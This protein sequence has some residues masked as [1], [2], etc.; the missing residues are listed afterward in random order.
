MPTTISLNNSRMLIPIELWVL[1]FDRTI[2]ET[3][4]YIRFIGTEKFSMTLSKLMSFRCGASKVPI[5][6]SAQI[7]PNCSLKTLVF[8][9]K[10]SDLSIVSSEHGNF[11]AVTTN[12]PFWVRNGYELPTEIQVFDHAKPSGVIAFQFKSFNEESVAFLS[13]KIEVQQMLIYQSVPQEKKRPIYFYQ[14]GYSSALEFSLLWRL[15]HPIHYTFL[16]SLA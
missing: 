6:T 10:F 16:L 13:R 2:C 7:T 5:V 1:S 15:A 3:S 14:F 8:T 12:T 4:G 9:I 11:Y